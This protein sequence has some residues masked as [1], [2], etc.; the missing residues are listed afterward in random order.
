[1]ALVYER[2]GQIESAIEKL[3]LALTIDSENAKIK[4]KLL[5]LKQMLLK[6]SD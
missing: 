6:K 4:Q 5:Q 3:E 2:L 1:M